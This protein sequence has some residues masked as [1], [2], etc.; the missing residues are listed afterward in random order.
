VAERGA[1]HARRSRRAPDRYFLRSAALADAIVADACVEPDELV[2]DVGAGSGRLT[3]PLARTGAH[4]RAIE[5]DRVNAQRLRRRFAASPNVEVVEGDV[6][7]LT[8]PRTPFRV[9]ANLPFGSTTATVRRLVAAPLVQADLIVEWGFATKRA[10]VLPST[11][12]GVVWGARYDVT[13]VRR[14]PAACFEPKPSV[15]AAVLRLK[16][17]PVPLVDSPPAFEAFVRECFE[18][19]A[20]AG[21]PNA[22]RRAAHE[23]GVDRRSRPWELDVHQWAALFD[24]V[25]RSGY[26][27]PRT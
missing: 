12:L 11:L 19:R 26:S 8:L 18:R 20:L 23:L 21:P 27:A 7:A 1:Q 9:V 15:D 13:L 14:L 25:R 4:V 17:R 3:A 6:L 16:Q 22:V 5:L 10:A 24:A 2:L